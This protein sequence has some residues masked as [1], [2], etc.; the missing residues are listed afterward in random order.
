MTHARLDDEFRELLSELEDKP[1]DEALIADACYAWNIRS[2]HN[3]CIDYARRGLAKDP[4]HAGLYYELIIASS[5]DT[6]H[7][8]R[9]I[10]KELEGILLKKPKD[11]GCLRNLALSCFFL[12][13]EGEAEELLQRI[14]A[15]TRDKADQQTYETLAQLEF[16][17]DH[18]ERA[19]AY[20]D[21][22]IARPGPG[23]RAVRLKGL[24]Y[25]DLG[26]LDHA[27][28]CFE[29]ALELEPNFVWAC[30]SLAALCMEREDYAEAFRYFG[31][32]TYI[33][34]MDP[35]NLFLLAEAFMDMEDYDLAAAELNKLLLCQPEPRIEAE[36]HNALG[37]LW[38]KMD[39][40]E[41]A[42]GHLTQA[43]DLEPELAV[44][45]Y[46][47]GQLAQREGHANLAERHF[48][49]AL[50]LDPGHVESHVELG[51]LHLQ[52]KEQEEAQQRFE[53]A[54]ELDLHEPQAHLGLS[55][56]AQQRRQANR[57]LEYARQA[58]E[59]DPENPEIMNNLGIAW[60]CNRDLDQAERCYLRALELDD[61]HSPAANNLGYLYEKKMKRHPDEADD[62]R[63]KA[64]DAWTRRLQICV[65]LKK[66]TKAATT[67]LLKLG[68]SKEDIR[69]L[70]K[71]AG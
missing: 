67:H 8:L 1:D 70:A 62:Y 20:C 28:S 34:P 55:K 61:R 12:E 42:R 16:S 58:A 35:G 36:V 29:Q 6:A 23:A 9:E 15:Q 5:L 13:E 53:T 7:I 41:R 38:L 32:A 39:D 4:F 59:M 25:Q 37:Y 43:I 69:A 48:K 30:H 45:Y 17:R 21:K 14:I 64:V 27:K 49:N 57:Q 33:N 2:Y 66:S 22:A 26:E 3:L 10:Q 40:L 51:F 54:L 11:L 63:H 24:C 44:A 46:N 60:E 52:H 47:L 68:L 56:L 31:K 50:S 71:Q 65:A 18:L 19:L